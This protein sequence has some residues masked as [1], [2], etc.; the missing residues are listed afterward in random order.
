MS[1]CSQS[2]LLPVQKMSEINLLVQ[3]WAESSSSRTDQHQLGM[4]AVSY[5]APVGRS[6]M[7][8]NPCHANL[9]LGQDGCSHRQLTQDPRSVEGIRPYSALLSNPLTASRFNRLVA[10]TVHVS[11]L[12]FP[13]RILD[14][15]GYHPTRHTSVVLAPLAR[16]CIS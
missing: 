9:S 10:V 12:F 5:P 16:I 3:P 8:L 7:C 6:C 11:P 13:G 2:S 1:W 14:F 4:H 15:F